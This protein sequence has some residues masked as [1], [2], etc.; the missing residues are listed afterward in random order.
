MG[1]PRRF[2]RVGAHSHIRGLGL[3]NLKALPIADGMVGQ[4]EAREAAGIIVQMIKEGRMAGRAI[5]LAGP[6]GTGKTAIALAMTKELG[7]DVP[8]VTLSGSEIYSTE[9]K[10]TEV[11]IQA[12]RKA[13][14][15]RIREMRRVYEGELTAQEIRMTKHPYNPYQQ[16]PESA[17]ITLATKRETKSF[18]I[19]QSIAIAL[20]NQGIGTGDVIQIDAETG[21][22]TKL[23]R[24]EE[25]VTEKYDIEAGETRVPRPS[26][27]IEKEKEFVYVMTLND[28]DEIQAR[29]GG[30]FSLLFGAGRQEVDPEV[31]RRV[32]DSIKSMVEEDRA[33][34]IP[35]VLFIDEVHMLDVEAYS[36]ISR[37]MES[38][39]APIIILASNRG[40]TRVRGTEIESPHG[41]PLDLLDRLLIVNTRLYTPEEIK[42]ILKIRTKE[43]RVEI[44]DE[45]LD[46]LTKIGHESSLRYAVQL[47]TPAAE[48]ARSKGKSQ[49]DVE[50]IDQVKALFSDVRRSVETLKQYEDKMMA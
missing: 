33:E 28:L 4:T 32:D 46:F 17:K 22:V 41:M 35:G 11:L 44:T 23:G 43:E 24:S 3:K 34:I 19:G 7:P 2:E 26:G 49:V 14:G 8:F 47:L 1:L 15:V 10:K 9:L 31:R 48:V 30:I 12:M 39:L 27:P 50:E 6:P 21:R 42:E 13:L 5:L 38:E 40:I 29:S 45:A 36:F 37:S 16:I 25:A 20:I 18:T